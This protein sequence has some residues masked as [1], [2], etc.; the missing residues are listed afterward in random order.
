MPSPTFISKYRRSWE[1][2]AW[3]PPVNVSWSLSFFAWTEKTIFS[4]SHVPPR[5]NFKS[6]AM[7]NHERRTRKCRKYDQYSIESLNSYQSRQQTI[8]SSQK[9]RKKW[10]TCKTGE[11]V[12]SIDNFINRFTWSKVNHQPFNLQ[13]SEKPRYRINRKSTWY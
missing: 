1:F 2:S 5:L 12:Y 3:F 9:N 10:T 11:S 7:R 6:K 8:G 13:T 4:D